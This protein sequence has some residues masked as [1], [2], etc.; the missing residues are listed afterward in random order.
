MARLV[1]ALDQCWLNE[2]EDEEEEEETEEKDDVTLPQI[3]CNPIRW[4]EAL[5]SRSAQ[6]AKW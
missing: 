5:G 4:P 6:S 1:V 2:K 3:L